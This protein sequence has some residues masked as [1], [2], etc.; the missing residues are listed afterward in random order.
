MAHKIGSECIGCGACVS[1]CPT[2]CIYEDGGVV[3]IKEAECILQNDAL[4]G[5]QSLSG[6]RNLI[7]CLR[8]SS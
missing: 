8:F 6:N 2:N 4:S 1:E 3:A 5:D 7:S